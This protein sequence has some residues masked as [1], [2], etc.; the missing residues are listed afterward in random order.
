MKFHNLLEYNKLIFI[1]I[2]LV[3]Y[4]FKSNFLKNILVRYYTKILSIDDYNT[5][6]HVDSNMNTYP[7]EE[8]KTKNKDS[9]G[10]SSVKSRQFNI[11][12]SFSNVKKK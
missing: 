4:L 2:L 6:K 7:L 10:L 11:N 3:F 8:I 9:L 5:G 12:N 1:V